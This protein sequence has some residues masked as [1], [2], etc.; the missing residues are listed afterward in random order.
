M[1]LTNAPV[2]VVRP[3]HDEEKD[4]ELVHVGTTEI[5]GHTAEV[6]ASAEFFLVEVAGERI[7][8]RVQ[9]LVSRSLAVSASAVRA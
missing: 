1:D 6:F 3:E 4:A 8:V 2:P 9:D 7:A 5:Q